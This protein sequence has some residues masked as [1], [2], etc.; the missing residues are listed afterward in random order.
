[1]CCFTRG[2]QTVHN[3]GC[4]PVPPTYNSWAACKFAG[5]TDTAAVLVWAFMRC[6]WGGGLVFGTRWGGLAVNVELWPCRNLLLLVLWKE[7]TMWRRFDLNSK[8]FT[9]KCALNYAELHHWIL[10]IDALNHFNVAAVRAN[11][12]VFEFPPQGSINLHL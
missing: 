12:N 8:V 3:P 1:M 4:V 2:Q 6:W 10:N 5:G 7:K 9:S 11:F